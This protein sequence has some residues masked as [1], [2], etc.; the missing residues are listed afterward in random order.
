MEKEFWNFLTGML[1]FV[2]TKWNEKKLFLGVMTII[3]APR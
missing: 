3:E 2:P 1:Q